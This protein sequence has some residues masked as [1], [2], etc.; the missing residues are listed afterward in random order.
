MRRISALIAGVAIC[1]CLLTGCNEKP[2]SYRFVKVMPNGTEQVESISAMNDTDALKQYLS[3]MEKAVLANIDKPSEEQYK[4]MYV[5]SPDRCDHRPTCR[6][7]GYC[8]ENDTAEEAA[9][10]QPACRCQIRKGPSPCSRPL[11]CAV[12]FLLDT[13]TASDPS[14]LW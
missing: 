14:P 9:P 2:K 5:I 11:Y 12:S 1:G 10:R 4:A 3:A 7:T 13:N 8:P 6:R